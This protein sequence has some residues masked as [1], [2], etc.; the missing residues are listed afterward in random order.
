MIQDIFNFNLISDQLGT[1]GMPSP[2]QFLDIQ[3]AGFESVIDLSLSESKDHLPDEE[4]LVQS[5]GMEYLH[6]PVV[7][8]SPRLEDLQIFFNAMGARSEK[9]VF[10]HCV[11]NY[12]ASVFVY[13]YRTIQLKE[14]QT[15]A[16]ADLNRIW[17]P[18]GV[19]VEFIEQA[20][21]AF[22]DYRP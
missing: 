6:I 17:I 4:E 2:D 7:W 22:S 3:Q 13:L 21:S 9:K 16:H 14:D 18:E 1:S 10:V 5:L 11:A 20:Q 8:E 12:R 15:K 19:W